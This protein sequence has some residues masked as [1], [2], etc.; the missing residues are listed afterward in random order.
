M[1]LDV[2]SLY[3]VAV[4]HTLSRHHVSMGLDQLIC[5]NTEATP[6]AVALQNLLPDG[7]RQRVQFLA[8][9]NLLNGLVVQQVVTKHHKRLPHRG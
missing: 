4:L 6:L 2:P 7:L 1:K 9:L 8:E 5:P 3:L